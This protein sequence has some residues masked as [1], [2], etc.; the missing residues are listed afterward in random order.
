MRFEGG[1]GLAKTALTLDDALRLK[2]LD[3]PDLEPIC[4]N[5]SKL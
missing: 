5:I 3:E 4:R 1:K 2:A